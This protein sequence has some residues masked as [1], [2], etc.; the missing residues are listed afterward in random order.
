MNSHE[1]RWNLNN[2]WQNK[3]KIKQ[4]TDEI[5]E[6]ITNDGVGCQHLTDM[7]VGSRKHGSVVDKLVDKVDYIRGLESELERLVRVNNAITQIYAT[8][9]EINITI[10][11]LRYFLTSEPMDVRQRKY[12][13][14]QIAELLNYSED[15]VRKM[16]Q[17]IVLK[18][19]NKL[20]ST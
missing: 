20:L 3:D 1:I 4:L 17:K 2:Y 19:Q 16:D 14:N 13:W 10:L 9:N 12:N 11:E 5:E 8:L 7:P 15:G 18:I 6:L